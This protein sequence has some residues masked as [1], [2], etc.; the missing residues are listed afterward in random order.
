[1]GVSPFC[2]FALIMAAIYYLCIEVRSVREIQKDFPSMLFNA[3]FFVVLA[4]VPMLLW[5]G[6][7]GFLGSVSLHSSKTLSG[8]LRA[9]LDV[10]QMFVHSEPVLVFAFIAGLVFLLKK[11]RALAAFFLLWFVTYAWVFYDLFRFDPRFFLPFIPI[12]ALVGGYFF[13]FFWR[14][15]A[16][17]IACLLLIIPLATSI[18]LAYLAHGSDTRARAREWI[19][20]NAGTGDWVMVFSSAMHIPTQPLATREMSAQDPGAVRQ[21]DKADMTLNRTDVPEVFNNLTSVTN[22]DFLANFQ[23]YMVARKYKYFIVE[24]SSMPELPLVA[25]QVRPVID[26]KPVIKQFNGFGSDMSLFDSAFRKPFTELFAQKTLGPDIL[27]YQLH[28]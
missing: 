16:L 12:F 1:M 13:S 27:I 14:K 25:A 21:D 15:N 7:N 6:G 18:R 22:Q 28:E 19:L 11:H 8:F 5:H 2:A 20:E 9:P 24:P 26:G 23:H 3:G 17:A 4:I 10:L